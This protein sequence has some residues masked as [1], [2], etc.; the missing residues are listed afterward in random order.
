MPRSREFQTLAVRTVLRRLEDGIF[1]VPR[2][3][4]EFVWNG[5]KAAKLIDSIH[6]N[7]PIGSI[8]VWRAKRSDQDLLRSAL[9]ILP[10]Y[11]P[12]NSEV[13]YVLDGQQ[14]L[15]VLYQA[16]KG[17]RKQNARRQD[18]DFGR[19]VFATERQDTKEGESLFRYRKSVTNRFV[20]LHRILGAGWLRNLERAGKGRLS[21][22]QKCREAILSYRIPFV[23][24]ESNDLEEIRE[25]FVRI[26]SLGTPISSA[27]RAFARAAVVD[28]RQMVHEVVEGLPP[29]FRGLSGEMLLQTLAL[30]RGVRDVGE[31]AYEPVLRKLEK[32]VTSSKVEK[33][34]L[35]KDWKRLRRALGKAVDYLHSS[36]H[37]LDEEFLP[38][39]YM[40]ALLTLFFVHHPAAPSSRQRAEIRKWFWATGVA[41]RYSGR[42]FR[43]NIIGDAD[44]F[45]RLARD[46]K[47][48]F[49]LQERVDISDLSRADYS[50]RA[51]ISDAF[52]CLLAEREPSYIENGEPLPLQVYASR[53][54]A[55]NK[56]HIFPRK[57]L[58]PLKIAARKINSICNICFVVAE[59]NQSIGSKP[60]RR[61]LEAHRRKQYFARTMKSHLI[62]YDAKSGLWD[63]NSRRGF[64]SFLKVREAA[65]ARAF[66]EAAG[67]KLFRPG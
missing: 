33:N 43:D 53:A 26:N 40:I 57:H 19:L 46:G 13:W 4:R 63:P 17:E 50:R 56:H 64:Q 61:Y 51:S 67:M 9:N 11:D 5:T 15:S 27:D 30:I 3:Q 44:F 29:G 32:R 25:L 55:K 52:F 1:A 24:I 49:Q 10:P 31:R 36:L 18:V 65:I 16:L 22:I 7:L 60:P 66:E 20:P 39:R 12:T 58:R 38:S 6:R 37:V 62:P 14:R 59:E 34:S 2:L 45:R 35:L 28:L 48:R 41:Q 8:V 23:F 21:R 42:G 54:N 47:A